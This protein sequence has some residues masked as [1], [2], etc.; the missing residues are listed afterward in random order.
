MRPQAVQTR[1][2]SGL[3][4]GSL[5]FLLEEE[6]VGIFC[7]SFLRVDLLDMRIVKLIPFTVQMVFGVSDVVSP[8]NTPIVGRNSD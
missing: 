5:L 1:G 7:D 4:V 2:L 3:N 8:W 6:H